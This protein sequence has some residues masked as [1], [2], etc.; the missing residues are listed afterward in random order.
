MLHNHALKLV[1][2]QSY[3]DYD[4]HLQGDSS[5]P[6]NHTPWESDNV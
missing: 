3:W 4:T 6:E 5:V 1:K 2:F